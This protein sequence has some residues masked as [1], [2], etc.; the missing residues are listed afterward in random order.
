MDI[1][2]AFPR[3]YLT[4]ADFEDR[5]KTLIMKKVVMAKFEDDQ[6]PVLYFED[7]EMGFA[8]NK[9][10]A[11]IV[12]K[13]YGKNTEEWAGKPL[14]LYHAM[15]EFRGDMV[16]AIRCRAPKTEPRKDFQPKTGVPEY[17]DDGYP[18]K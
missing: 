15:V 2:K 1:S 10:N 8:M 3:E 12:Q 17:D 6:K 5:P 13:L 14:T 4:A 11:N 18:I 7:E 16:P 9:T